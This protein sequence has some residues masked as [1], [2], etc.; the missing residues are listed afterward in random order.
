M[1]WQQ[2]I[3]RVPRDR[4]AEVEGLLELAGAASIALED[5]AE[6]PL[7]EPLPGE[8]PLWPEVSVKAL[9]AADVDLAPVR[10]ILH[11]TAAGDVRVT[12]LAEPDLAAGL[13]APLSI[14]GRLW[15]AS[16]DDALPDDGLA[17]VRLHRGVA[18]GTGEHPTTSLCLNW[19]ASSLE[20]YTV[21]LDYGC[22]SGIL[23]LAALGLGAVRAFAVDNDPQA[24]AAAKANAALNGVDDRIWIGPP[25][26]LPAA[27]VDVVLANIL[28]R[29]LV[30]LSTLFH[31][32]LVT[33][34]RAILSGALVGQRAD[35]ERAYV[36]AGFEIEGCVERDGWIRL[37][38]RKRAAA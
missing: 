16:A 29:P 14:G 33:G 3:A 25:D 19:I 2:L 1:A 11:V 13:F 28:A 6:A 31:A 26:A 27:R 23:A 37:D 32:R 7:F 21:V 30:E 22:G 9:F 20:P 15:V 24:V 36:T 12:P 10:D 18:F 35:L 38:A 17:V 34:G 8:T 4:V 5:A